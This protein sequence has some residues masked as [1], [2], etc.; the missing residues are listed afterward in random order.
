MAFEV[1]SEPSEG[2]FGGFAGVVLVGT[3]PR[4]CCLQDRHDQLSISGAY[5]LRLG[6]FMLYDPDL[7]TRLDWGLD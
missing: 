5:R 1:K 4:P 2:V 7:N 3:L 6:G